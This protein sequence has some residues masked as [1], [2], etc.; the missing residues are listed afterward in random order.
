MFSQ[1]PVLVVAGEGPP[2]ERVGGAL[3][4]GLL[5]RSDLERDLLCRASLAVVRAERTVEVNPL[6]RLPG[7]ISINRQS[8]SEWTGRAFFL[9]YADLSDF[10]PFNDKYGFSRATR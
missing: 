9:A 5:R 7:N 1:L 4:R 3:R 10:K 8:R 6:T 2:V